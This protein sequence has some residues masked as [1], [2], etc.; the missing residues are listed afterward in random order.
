MYLV[1]LVLCFSI[2]FFGAMYF[3]KLVPETYIQEKTI[4]KVSIPLILLG[5]FILSYLIHIILHELGHL[6]FGLATGYSFVSFR[7]GSLVVTKE[8]GR[9]KVRKFSIPGTAGQCLLMP[10]EMKDGRFPYVIYNLGGVILNFAV[11]VVSF[12]LALSLNPTNY[13]ARI[14]LIIFTLGGLIVVITNGI[15]LKISGVANDA[16]NVMSMMKD[17]DARR[18]FYLQLRVNGLLHQG[19][20]VRD[21]DKNLFKFKPDSDVTSPLITGLKLMECNWYLDKLDFN[22]ARECLDSLVRHLKDIVPLYRWEINCE[23]IFLELIGDCDKE[24]IDS[25]YDKELTK[26]L[27]MAKFMPSKKRL[28]IAYEAYYNKDKTRALEY[29]EEFLKLYNKYPIKGEAEMELDLV[30]CV[31]D[32]VKR[33]P[34]V[35]TS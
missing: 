29:Y 7:V 22:G 32:E 23:R 30:N 6:V 1:F 10:P 34:S 26:Y 9:F 18:G 20:R 4:F 35:K 31:M 14:S 19:I 24:L 8:D 12:F 27:K 2:G 16:H 3:D 21:M 33:L 13:L 25:L 28:L 11:S 17:E 5:V 15:P